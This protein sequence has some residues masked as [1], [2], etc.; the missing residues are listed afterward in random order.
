MSQRT[1][2]Q[3]SLFAAIAEGVASQEDSAR[4]QRLEIALGF[5][6]FFTLVSLIS[7]VVAT[8]SGK[9]AV[10][11]ALISA[12][13]VALTYPVLRRWQAVGREIADK[14]ARVGREVRR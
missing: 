13:F 8:L 7:T 11:E 1:T 4:L 2:S 6:G 9:P 5:G 12:G 3:G 14:A 10:A